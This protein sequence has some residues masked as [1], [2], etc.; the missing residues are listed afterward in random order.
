[1]DVYLFSLPEYD[2]AF[3]RFAYEA[4]Q[5]LGCRVSGKKAPQ[6]HLAMPGMGGGKKLNSKKVGNKWTNNLTIVSA[7]L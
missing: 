4:L 1:M 7:E 6:I 5:N 2:R 3:G